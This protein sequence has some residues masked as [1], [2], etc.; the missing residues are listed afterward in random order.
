MVE[1]TVRITRTWD[2]KVTAEYGDTDEN[3]LDKAK[4]GTIEDSKESRNLLP[5]EEGS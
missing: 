1:R 5:M 4:A 3:L 2:V